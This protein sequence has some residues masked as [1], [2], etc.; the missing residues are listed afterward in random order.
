MHEITQVQLFTLRRMALASALIKQM[1]K[2]ENSSNEACDFGS[3]LCIVSLAIWPAPEN[4]MLLYPK[5][6]RSQLLEGLRP[7]LKL[8]ISHHWPGVSC[9]PSFQGLHLPLQL[10]LKHLVVRQQRFPGQRAFHNSI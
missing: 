2:F 5:P 10:K 3:E 9:F 1:L 6:H 4:L 7:T 8:S